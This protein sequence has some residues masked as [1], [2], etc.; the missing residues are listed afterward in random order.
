MSID[1]ERYFLT[2]GAAFVR[3]RCAQGWPVELPEKLATIPLEDLP[4][5]DLAAIFSC[6]QAAGL[7]MH[8]FKRTM[9]LARVQR[10]FGVLRNIGPAELLDV[11]SGRGAFLWPL[12][13]EF[14]SLPVTA[15]DDDPV[16][17]RDIE[18][19]RLGGI[20]RLTGHK[21]DAAKL[22]FPVSAFDVVSLLEVL[23][24]IPNVPKALAEALRVAR[25]FVVLSVPSKPDDNPD[26][27]HLLDEKTLRRLF[28][29]LGITRVTFDY[30]PGH[31]IAVAN[32]GR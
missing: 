2:L 6:G 32:V 20:D 12:M 8:K 28:S 14:P 21:M 11:G 22:D 7:E 18:A 23:E 15:I 26:H 3:G 29:D 16:R 10:V 19:V 24:H 1:G 13:D 25:R 9:G 27:L 31:V 4:E 5:D 30:V 17:A